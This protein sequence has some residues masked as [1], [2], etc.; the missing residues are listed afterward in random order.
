[1]SRRAT[2]LSKERDDAVR[3]CKEATKEAYAEVRE[4]V[5]KDLKAKDKAAAAREEALAE[6]LENMQTALQ[7]L[8]TT[9]ATKEQRMRE[10]NE[11]LLQRCTESE[12]RCQELSSAV[13]DSTRPLL[14]Q[15]ESL[16]ANF[17][18]KTRVWE[19]VELSLRQRC[20]TAEKEARAA[21]E[22]ERV[23]HDKHHTLHHSLS[24]AEARITALQVCAC[25]RARPVL[26]V[27]LGVLAL[28]W[29]R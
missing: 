3:K 20:E 6:S 18:E 17:A 19:Q 1:M 9:S 22:K 14:R 23:S 8:E 28:G 24:T 11:H 7:R 29:S 10:E 16:H 13:P 26:C 2:Q 21:V 5:E 25:V 27:D 15:I 4:Q 12:S